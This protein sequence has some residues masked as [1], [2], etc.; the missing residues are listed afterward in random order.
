MIRV[1]LNIIKLKMIV[2]ENKHCKYYIIVT[3]I[4]HILV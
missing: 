4:L 3:I 1:E 2:K